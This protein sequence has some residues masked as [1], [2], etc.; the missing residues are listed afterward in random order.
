M[1]H[2]R[3][4]K[5]RSHHRRHRKGGLGAIDFTNILGVAAGAVA[6]GMLN[7]VIPESVNTKIVAG[8]KMALGIALPMFV[9][10]GKLKGI[11]AGV[12][13]GMIAVGAV[14]L[15]KSFGVLSGADDTMSLSLNGD[16]DMLSADVLGADVLGADDTISGED[17]STVSGDDYM[18][19]D[20]SV[21]SGHDDEY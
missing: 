1:K 17:I 3:K 16:Q 12:G 15:L 5:K 14:D 20:I 8:G 10:S 6:A 18:N 13:S 19:G 4:H 11:M 2:K 9:K 7:K 21:V